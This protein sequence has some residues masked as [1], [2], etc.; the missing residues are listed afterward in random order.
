MS[1]ESFGPSVF[2][3]K[4]HRRAKKFCSAASDEISASCVEIYRLITQHV[5]SLWKPG[6]PVDTSC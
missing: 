5:G 6:F 1:S 3:Q 4:N 2:E